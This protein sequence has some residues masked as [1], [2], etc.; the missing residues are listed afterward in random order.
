M[1]A[2]ATQANKAGYVMPVRL[3]INSQ[4]Q[5]ATRATGEIGRMD[6]YDGL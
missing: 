5:W 1:F 2:N 4:S 6:D 3:Y